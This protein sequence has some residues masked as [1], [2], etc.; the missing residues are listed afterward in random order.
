MKSAT[1]KYD[2]EKIFHMYT[3]Y[4]LSS[5][6]NI[7]SYDNL[8]F[9]FKDKV[10]S[11]NRTLKDL[12]KVFLPKTHDEPVEIYIKEDKKIKKY[13]EQPHSDQD[14]PKEGSSFDDNN[15]AQ[16]EKEKNE[17]KKIKSEPKMEIPEDK[18]KE[19][20]KKENND[21]IIDINMNKKDK[22]YLLIGGFPDFEESL[23]KRGWNKC[24]D[25]EKLTYDL[26]FTLKMTDIPFDDLGESVIINHYRKISE[27]TK[28]TGLLKNI[29]N[30]YNLNICPD[31]FYPRAYELSEKQDVQDFIEDFKISKAISLLRQCEEL[32]GKNVNR[33]EI[34]TALKIVKERLNILIGEYNLE[35]KF[36]EVKMRTFNRNYE[37]NIKFEIKKISDED[38][39]IISNENIN[40]YKEQ[41]SRI[42]RNGLI[43]KDSKDNKIT[44][45]LVTKNNIKN[46]INKNKKVVQKNKNE[47]NYIKNEE[48]KKLEEEI[49]ADFKLKEKERLIEK[50]K[51]DKIIK[52]REEEQLKI[53]QEM[54]LK[55]KLE[56]EKKLNKEPPKILTKEE[57]EQKWKEETFLNNTSSNERPQ[58]LPQTDDVSELIPEISEILKKLSQKFPQY[59]LGGN[60][61]IWIVK[62]SGLSRGRGITCIDQLNDIL[63]NIRSHNQTVIQKYIEN[64][65]VIK[66]RKFDIRQWVLLTNLN[67]LTAYLFDTPYIRFGAED[68]HLDD[69]KN[70]FSQLTGN[71]IAKHSTKFENSEIEGD[72]WEIDQ[73]REFLKNREG[74]DVWPEMQEKIKKIVIYAL[75]CAKHKI[76]KR[77]NSFEILGFD[78]M[79]DDLLNVYLIEINLSP[80][81]TYSTKVTEKLI[82]IAS[83]DII[84]IIV[85]LKNDKK[86]IDTG[87]FKLIY[88]SEKLPT[89]DVPYV[90][91]NYC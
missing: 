21:N 24:P 35:N 57:K 3:K 22:E 42:Q 51:L 7:M 58:R 66:G 64:P 26:I 36:E 76:M 32:K 39:E 41:I 8:I 72:M 45:N 90:N 9:K 59:V 65:L 48:D 12:E 54:Q 55:K 44:T 31:D 91:K 30:L 71:S 82:K 43:P 33:K 84:K 23:K 14:E 83:E 49:K 29:R 27:I 67:P 47:N 61:N 19:K 78:I 17:L 1:N 75:F 34:E 25:S 28:K 87:R 70:I 79:V 69:F 4:R 68:F 37:K 13:E 38:W 80:D 52:E 10:N 77:K 88:N 5:F 46:S 74:K 60:R 16:E 6:S 11:Y 56:E 15:E 63:S 85:D 62:P 73:F 18:N 89:F 81:W 40:F 50:E 53:E 20:E 2:Y 86:D